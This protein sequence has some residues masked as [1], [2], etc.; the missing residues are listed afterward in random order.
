VEPEVSSLDFAN[1][2][3]IGGFQLPSLLTRRVQTS[4]E[5][6]PGQHLGIAGL[7]DNT[8][9]AEAS[10]LPLLGDLP[11]IGAFFRTRSSRDRN[12]EL[13]VLVT[14]HIVEPTDTPPA[15]P[16]GETRTWDR[17]DY[18]HEKTLDLPAG[19]RVVPPTRPGGE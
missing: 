8:T 3:T 7:L 11:I 14:P 19:V 4:V 13:L 17:T 5:L 2:I 10:K 1:G 9:L 12:T 15:L 18:M 16:T 6:R